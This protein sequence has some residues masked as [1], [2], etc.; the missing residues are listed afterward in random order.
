MYCQGNNLGEDNK[1]SFLLRNNSE[2]P[3]LLFSAYFINHLY[4]DCMQKKVVRL[5]IATFRGM[6]KIGKMEKGVKNGKK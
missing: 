3:I 6:I 4:H 5:T 1:S 2:N